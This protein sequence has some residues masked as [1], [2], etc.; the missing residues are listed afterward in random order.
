MSLQE[1][2]PLSTAGNGS[3]YN[4][5]FATSQDN[6]AS[7]AALI[8]A[9]K[10]GKKKYYNAVGGAETIQ[11]QPVHV[12]YADGGQTNALVTG[13]TRLN[14]TQQSQSALD[15]N[16]SKTGGR[17]GRRSNKNKKTKKNKKNKQTKKNKKTNKTKKTKRN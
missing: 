12:A 14:A 6:A 5:G 3:I 2:K 17:R 10:G 4:S 1:Y 8:N 11:V 16:V 13:M 9:S 7:Q 15:S